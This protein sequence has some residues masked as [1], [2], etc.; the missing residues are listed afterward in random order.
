MNPTALLLI[1]SVFFLLKLVNFIACALKDLQ[2]VFIQYSPLYTSGLF[3]MLL[4]NDTVGIEKP[5]GICSLTFAED[6][7]SE[8]LLY[9]SNFS[10][11]HSRSA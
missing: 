10:I 4:N 7:F 11:I 6:G 3:S 5:Y 9:P 2:N 8:L 1:I